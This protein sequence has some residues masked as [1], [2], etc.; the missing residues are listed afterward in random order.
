MSVNALWKTWDDH[1]SMAIAGTQ[2]T[3]NGFSI[4]A[5]RTNF[6][7]KE[8]N[9]MLDAGL[10]ANFSPDYIMV[11][12]CHSD[13]S[14]NLPYH[15]YSAKEGQKIQIYVPGKSLNNFR[16]LLDSAYELSTHE[17]IRE[18]ETCYQLIPVDDEVVTFK[19][20]NKPFE[21]EVIPCDHGVPCVGYGF[22]EMRSKL[23]QEYQSMS[24]KELGQLRKS[25]IELSLLV[26]HYF[27]CYLGD[28]SNKILENDTLWK[29]QTIMIE[30]TF[31]HEDEL[32]QAAKTKHIHWL[33][34]K[35]YVVAHHDNFF[36]LYHFSQRY[37]KSD[38]VQ[39][40]QKEK[41][42]NIHAWI[43]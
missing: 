20:R 32:P 24:Q 35:P 28:T 40:F 4:C 21:L 34:L 13:H 16:R 2:Y 22:A 3:L 8:L 5:L 31:I 19:I 12:H 15:L 14:A 29:Y 25:G 30:C 27:L 26:P 39:Y 10:S 36:I 38:I 1:P 33:Q 9:L 41:L 6:Y 23:K 17:A 7:I 42:N 37:K 18:E 11:T 43:N